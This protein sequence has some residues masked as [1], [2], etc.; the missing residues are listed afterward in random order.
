MKIVEMHC[1]PVAIPTKEFSRFSWGAQSSTQ[2]IIVKLFTD[3]G[4][5]GLGECAGGLER[6][7]TLQAIQPS[8]LGADPFQIEKLRWMIMAPASVTY[9]GNS[10]T[11]AFAAVE[12]ACFD[13]MGKATGKRVVDLIG[14]ALYDAV[15]CAAYAFF[16]HPSKEQPEGISTPEQM[17][18]YCEA[19]I[20]N[21]GFHTIKVKGG[22]FPPEQEL[23]VLVALQ[24]RFPHVALRWDPNG[25]WS[26]STAFRIIE[27]CRERNLH[28]E[29]LEDPVF[30]LTAMATVR[31]KAGS[32]PLATNTCVFSLADL[33]RAVAERPADILL[34]DLHWYGGLTGLR[35]LAQICQ[36]FDFDLGLHSARELGISMAAHIHAVA[37]LS[38]ICGT[39]AIDAHYH[40]LVDD[41][42]TVP[43]RYNNGAIAVPESPGLGVALDS[44]KVQ[45]Y[46]EQYVHERGQRYNEDPS[47]PD[48]VVTLPKW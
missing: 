32:L 6:E 15:P 11:H 1:T 33:P 30:G 9:W 20:E 43:L 22:V 38:N 42:L 8:V 17:V 7:G 27:R 12:M 45:L 48:V 26:L 18:R 21:Y 34:G 29:Y 5:I 2:R 41:V 37:S 13:L 23:D 3:D 31:Q 14:G 36:V 40:M 39:R 16:Q 25:V 19:L 24:E 44:E 35:T 47:H 28:L 10:F 46:H 4:L